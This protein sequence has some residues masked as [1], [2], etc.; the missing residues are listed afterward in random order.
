[1]TRQLVVIAGLERGRILALHDADILQLGCSQNLDVSTRFRDPEI[2]RVHCEIQVHGQRVLL[3]D[4]G[5]VFGT[6]VNGRRITHEEL[7][8]GDVIRIGHTELRYVVEDSGT[9]STG[10][11]DDTMIV[12]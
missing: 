6:Y 11:L 8:P 4:S 2:A 5:T 1:M 12:K 3:A 9:C 7:Q 10:G